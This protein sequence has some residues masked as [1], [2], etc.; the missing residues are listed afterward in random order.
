MEVYI[1]FEKD[2]Q[3]EVSNV[4]N[5]SFDQSQYCLEVIFRLNST[6]IH[7]FFFNKNVKIFAEAGYV[8][9]FTIVLDNR[10]IVFKAKSEPRC[11]Y[12]Q[13]PNK[14]KNM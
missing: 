7:I 10:S 5:K 13:G 4:W 1:L 14:K 2:L 8:L 6:D 3:I 12:K 11:S 9:I